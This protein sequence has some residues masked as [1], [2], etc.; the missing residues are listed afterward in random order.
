MGR[1]GGSR[2]SKTLS[3]IIRQTS[4]FASNGFTKH[5][6]DDANFWRKAKADIIL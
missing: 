6:K 4:V 3:R 1:K 2:L 5:Q